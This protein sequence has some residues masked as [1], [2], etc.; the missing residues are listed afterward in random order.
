VF[1]EA[2]ADAEMQI[3]LLY[4]II[5]LGF[6]HLLDF[7]LALPLIKGLYYLHIFILNGKYFSLFSLFTFVHSF[8]FSFL[9]LLFIHYSFI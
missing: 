6:H 1:S 7:K 5:L 4:F 3:L 9:Y 8:S 2:L